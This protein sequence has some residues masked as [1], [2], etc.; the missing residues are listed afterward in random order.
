MV[1]YLAS[2]SE[3][4]NI[5]QLG[6]NFWVHVHLVCDTDIRGVCPG[7]RTTWGRGVII[8]VI[9]FLVFC[10]QRVFIVALY[11]RAGM[12]FRAM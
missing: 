2:L 1:V 3:L 8:S 5:R 7:T 4:G 10:K 9:W 12:G 6:V 11:L